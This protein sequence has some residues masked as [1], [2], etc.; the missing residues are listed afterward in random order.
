MS[1]DWR[2]SLQDCLDISVHRMMAHANSRRVMG[3]KVSAA[4]ALAMFREEW[5][6]C[7]EDVCTGEGQDIAEFY[8]KG[9]ACTRKYAEFIAESDGSSII[10]FDI[11]GV[12]S[13]PRGKTARV[14]IDEIYR[15]GDSAV[16]CRYITDDAGLRKDLTEDLESKVSAL[17]ATYSLQGT[18]RIVLQWRYLLTG[19][20]TECPVRKQSM[21]EAAEKLSERIGEIEGDLNYP[22]KLGEG[23]AYCP[24]RNR[25]Q[26]YL[27]SINGKKRMPAEEIEELVQEYSDLDE[28][29]AALKQRMEM[30]QSRRDTVK[31]KIVAYADSARCDLVDGRDAT[32]SI[33][34]YRRAN[35]PK[36]KTAVIKRLKETG[37]Y[38][39]ISMVNYSRLRADIAK[40]IADPVISD[41][42]DITYDIRMSL[43]KK[44]RD[45]KST[46][47]TLTAVEHAITW[48]QMMTLRIASGIIRSLNHSPERSP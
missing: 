5:D 3:H 38:D 25:C 27:S 19:D 18:D 13:L 48:T 7:M 45:Q 34:R 33:R 17:W 15:R 32:I 44:K 22:P 37:Q 47:E 20:E 39:S 16:L 12:Q 4:E 14:S 24:H 9:E 40:G 21:G 10:A 29:I 11:R 23:C 1:D 46:R 41:M 30:L 2:I 35:L 31:A 8:R 6:A 28:K 43:I 36:D 26:P 42:A